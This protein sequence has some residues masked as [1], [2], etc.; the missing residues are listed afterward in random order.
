MLIILPRLRALLELEH[1][2]I[3]GIEEERLLACREATGHVV[4]VERRTGVLE[5]RLDLLGAKPEQILSAGAGTF[6]NWRSGDVR[7]ARRFASYRVKADASL[8]IQRDACRSFIEERNDTMAIDLR[9][10]TDAVQTYLNKKVAVAIT[11]LKATNG[12]QVDPGETFDV[13]LEATNADATSGV[14]LKNLKFRVSVDDGS[15]AKLIVPDGFLFSSTDL[16]GNSVVKGTERTSM[17]VSNAGVSRLI[18]GQSGGFT[19]SGK[20]SG[21]A[22]GGKTTVRARVLADVDLDE[23]FPQGEDSS[24]TTKALAVKG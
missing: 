11:E 24:Q 22:S 8:A 6:A 17:I 15:V 10:I 18:A 5:V 23:L 19:I 14:A 12:D 3:F 21:A 1:G 4:A 20:A 7:A 2:T 9:D 16:D 13:K